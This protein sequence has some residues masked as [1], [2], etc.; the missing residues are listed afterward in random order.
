MRLESNSSADA[1]YTNLE[2]QIASWKADGLTAQIQAMM[3]GAE[4][5][6]QAIDEQQAKQIISEGQALLKSYSLHLAAL[7]VFHWFFGRQRLGDW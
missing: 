7:H 5:N 1:N 4:F 3:E 2:N 6:G